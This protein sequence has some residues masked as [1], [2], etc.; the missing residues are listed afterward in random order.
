MLEEYNLRPQ[1]FTR[2]IVAEGSWEDMFKFEGKLLR[3]CDVRSDPDYYNQH[4]GSGDFYF[5]GHTEESKKKISAIHKG[6][7]LSTEHRQKLSEAN[8]GN[9][10]TLGKILSKEHKQKI[11]ESGK[12]KN[13]GKRH[14][15]ES[16]NLISE[17]RRSKCIGPQ[18]YM[19]D[20]THSEPTK[21]ILSEKAKQRKKETCPRCFRTMDISN[22][23]RHNHGDSCMKDSII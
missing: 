20:K 2:Q 8:K 13:L 3:T 18:N 5:K 15:E 22:F 16:K 23:R 21:K 7:I 12:G 1:D 14:S 17:N 11:S 4:N 19:Y 6:K 10:Y 9:K